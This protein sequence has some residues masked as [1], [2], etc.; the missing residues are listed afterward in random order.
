MT[1]SAQNDVVSHFLFLHLLSLET[2][3]AT[4][5]KKKKEEMLLAYTISVQSGQNR[6]QMV[7]HKSQVNHASLNP[8]HAF[9]VCIKTHH[10]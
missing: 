2:E 4:C 9:K 6:D 5:K 8:R 1:A 10:Q 3:K 7:S